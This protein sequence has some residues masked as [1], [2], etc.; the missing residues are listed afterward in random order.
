[1]KVLAV[2]PSRYASSRFPGKP[3]E[4][5][6]GKSMVQRVYEQVTKATR[7]DRVIVATDDNRIFEHVEGFNGEVLMTAEHHQNGTE[8]CAEVI[9]TLYDDFDIVLNIQGDEPFILPEQIDQLASCFDDET[10]DIAT[11]MKQTDSTEQLF[12]PN[13]AK[14]VFNED[15]IAQYF[16]RQPIP[17]LRGIPNEEWVERKAHYLH[18]GI[19][20]YRKEVLLDVVKLPVSNLERLEMLEQLRWLENGYTISVKQTDYQS[21][22]VDTPDDLAEA[23]NFLQHFPQFS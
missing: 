22:S 1:M 12:S 7:I 20:G 4:K 6:G 17:H 9:E 21:I 23:E 11:L 2:I 8:R 14:V 5:I 3:L 13:T 15:F 18:V 10:I 19:Y 16:S